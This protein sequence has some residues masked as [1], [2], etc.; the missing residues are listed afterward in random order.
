MHDRTFATGQIAKMKFNELIHRHPWEE[1]R[2]ALM[3]LYPEYESELAGYEQVHAALRQLAPAESDLVLRV[4]S[5]YNDRMGEYHANVTGRKALGPAAELGE[6][7]ELKLTPWERWLGME[8]DPHSLEKFSE[9]EI[10][11][12]CLWEMTFFG[13]SQE[14]IRAASEEITERGLRK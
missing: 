10:V 5:V 7:L 13:F 3:R 12:H 9:M 6:A 14:D 11:A 8:V 1:I 2:D 4:E